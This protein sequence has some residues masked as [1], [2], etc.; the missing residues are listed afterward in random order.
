MEYVE[1]TVHQEK[2]ESSEPKLVESIKAER[3]ALC[4]FNYCPTTTPIT[5]RIFT[6]GLSVLGFLNKV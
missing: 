1:L 5:R 2:S 4:S 6:K 3:S